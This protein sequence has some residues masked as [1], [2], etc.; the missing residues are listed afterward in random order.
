MRT[1]S[2]SELCDFCGGKLLGPQTERPVRG[3]VRDNRETEKDYCFAA[4][5]GKHLDGHDFCADAAERGASCCILEKEVPG[6][7]IPAVLVESVP[8]ALIKIAAALRRELKIPVVAVIGS[9]GKTTTKE[10][11]ASVLSQKYSILKTEGNH[12][13]LLGV[14][15]TV[16]RIDPGHEIAVLELGI[17]E[18]GEMSTLAQ[19]AAPDFAVFTAVGRS[20]TDNLHDLNG[21][22]KAKSE[23]FEYMKPDSKVYLSFDDKMLKWLKL[24]QQTCFYGAEDGADAMAFD[25]GYNGADGIEF[26]LRYKDRLLRLKSREFGRQ[27]VYAAS[28]ASAL[29]VDLGLSDEEIKSGV[30]VYK[31]FGSRARL[32]DSMGFN[33]I[34]DAY[35]ANPD[36]LILSLKSLCD[37]GGRKIAVLGDMYGLGEDAPAMHAE[38]VD[39]A[40]GLGIEVMSCGRFFP[41]GK[42]H[43]YETKEALKK[44]LSACIKNG[45]SV[46]VK[47][48]HASGF[49]EISAF[50]R[51]F[52]F[53]ARA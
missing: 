46:L 39:F 19:I 53:N 50:L 6:L 38:C 24:E 41:E 8:E 18:F 25:I 22:L 4:I 7:A 10:M 26:T 33:L 20:H 2:V 11:L 27:I 17:S 40:L 51:G 45:D 3:I 9:S 43:H 5:K 28:A 44:A 12:N 52:D 23:L 47:A 21:V 36:S 37:L 13:N 16:F 42:T 30:S 34:D 29:A 48:S 49:E 15:L 35:N 32:F 14:P 1:L 31:P